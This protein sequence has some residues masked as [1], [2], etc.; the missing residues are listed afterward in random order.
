MRKYSQSH[1]IIS[2]D[3]DQVFC[4]SCGNE[5]PKNDQGYFADYV[6]IEKQWGYFSG[7]DGECHTIDICEACYNKITNSFMLPIYNK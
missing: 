6:H 1:T 4:N 2:H 7:K 5:I 3:I